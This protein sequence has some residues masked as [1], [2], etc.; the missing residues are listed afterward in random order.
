MTRAL[1]YDRTC[2][3]P[4]CRQGLAGI[5]TAVKR[6]PRCR[7]RMDPLRVWRHRRYRGLIEVP[8]WM[9]AVPVFLGALA[10]GLLFVA[11]AH[12]QDTSNL[13]SFI[14]VTAFGLPWIAGAYSR[15]IARRQQHA[16]APSA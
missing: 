9:L 7:V 8:R 10:A 15:W 1:L 11:V 16:N 12:G 3:C 14:A 2:R 13:V 4:R 5:P 6:C